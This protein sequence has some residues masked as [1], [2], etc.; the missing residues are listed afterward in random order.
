MGSLVVKQILAMM[1]W[2]GP[3]WLRKVCEPNEFYNNNWF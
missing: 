3:N 2:S 1:V